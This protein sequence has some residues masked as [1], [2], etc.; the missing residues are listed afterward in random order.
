MRAV[1]LIISESQ[2]AF[3]IART[4]SPSQI[5]AISSLRHFE[6]VSRFW[7]CF[8][9]IYVTLLTQ[10]QIIF[11]IFLLHLQIS[12]GRHN[13]QTPALKHTPR[14][15]ID[16]ASKQSSEIKCCATPFL[17]WNRWSASQGEFQVWREMVITALLLSVVTYSNCHQSFIG[18]TYFKEMLVYCCVVV[19]LF[20]VDVIIQMG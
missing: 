4:V 2:K 10:K 14:L 3:L 8:L 7:R 20:V 17:C 16:Y 5:T 15:I 12:I 18:I 6:Y 1:R 9:K 19:F 11:W 13:F